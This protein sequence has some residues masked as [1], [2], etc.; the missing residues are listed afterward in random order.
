MTRMRA[1]VVAAALA[2]VTATSAAGGTGAASPRLTQLEGTE[3]PSRAYVLT[4]P[5]RAAVDATKVHVT[6]NGERVSR[7]EVVPAS[8]SGN[9][10]R[11]VVLVIDSSNSMA[12][13]P[14]AGAVTAAQA[15]VANRNGDQPVGVVTFNDGQFV[16][17]PPTTDADAIRDAL[18]QQ[19]FLAQGTH[20]YDAVKTALEALRTSN[21]TSGS[22]VLLSDGADTGSKTSMEAAIKAAK[23][24]H[25]KI[26]AVGLRS[27]AFK[28]GPLQQLAKGSGGRF[29]E[30]SN[31]DELAPIYDQ[32]GYELA[33]EYVMR[34]RSL[35]GPEETIKVVVKVD[36]VPGV[37]RSGYVTPALPNLVA[38]TYEGSPVDDFWRSGLSVLIVAL[39]TALLLAFGVLVLV[40]PRNRMLRSRMAEFV[41]LKNP[42]EPEAGT[43]IT[44]RVFSG[45]ERSLERSRFWGR[46]KDD[47]EIAE[48]RMPAVQIVLW[49]V[50]AT[51]FLAWVLLL[52]AGPLL[53]AFALVVPFISRFLVY[54]KLD[55]RRAAF[56]EQL[57]DNVQV[58]SSALR[59]GHSLVG[60]LSVVVDDSPE[61]SRSELRRVV[62][63]EQLGVPLEDALMRVAHRMDCADLE[64]IALVAAL[65][66]E[67]GGNTAEVLD[68]VNEGVRERFEL[69]RLVRTLTA[70]GRM[71]RWVVSFLPVA[72]VFA[73]LLINPT[74]LKP[75]IDEPIGR[76]L[77]ALSVVM[78][79]A[80]SLVIRRIVNIKV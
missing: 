53:A 34:Y 71:S 48:I 56:L 80:G 27:G 2:A 65:G 29:Y 60:A 16:T 7:L 19:P 35:A 78:V 61:P 30:A 15:L 50:V 66:R 20:I 22:M 24:A 32:L 41:T 37:G 14:I 47:L 72:L 58:L 52:V 68:R 76:L 43:R 69:R 5:T 57:P 67:T 70:Q 31:P 63:D 39:A 11:S 13:R 73:I 49:T 44:D 42:D 79:I 46:F 6:E 74:Y 10:G 18:A 55:R 77:I 75:L 38:P 4:L 33:N 40:R 62:A 59:A 25:V 36:G 45:T 12:G 8:A 9:R 26:Y 21:S 3:F 23:Q 28:P 1:I 54:R 17:L 64:Q 51:G